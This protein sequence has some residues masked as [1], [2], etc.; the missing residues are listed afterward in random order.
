MGEHAGSPLPKPIETTAHLI[1]WK[2]VGATLAVAQMKTK[3]NNTVGNRKGCPYNLKKHNKR[4][5]RQITH[6]IFL[7]YL[8]L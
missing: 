6:R 4:H 7:L 3:H 8:W 5:A 2:N 1:I